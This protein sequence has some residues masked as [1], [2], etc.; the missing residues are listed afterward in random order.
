LL[1]QLHGAEITAVGYQ[2][3]VGHLHAQ[4]S[5]MPTSAQNSFACALAALYVCSKLVLP[6]DDVSTVVQ[7][8]LLQQRSSAWEVQCKDGC[9]HAVM[10][11]DKRQRKLGMTSVRCAQPTVGILHLAPTCY[12]LL[13]ACCQRS[14]AMR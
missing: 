4:I 1:E 5:V 2:F 11:R 7:V 10:R 13:A 6:A 12:R 9:G 8:S 3:L 14:W